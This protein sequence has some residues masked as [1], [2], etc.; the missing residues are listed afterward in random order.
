MDESVQVQHDDAILAAA[1]GLL[2]KMMNGRP[3]DPHNCFFSGADLV[4][5]LVTQ[6]VLEKWPRED[7][8]RMISNLLDEIEN[9]RHE[10]D[11]PGKHEKV[12]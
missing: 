8:V 5:Q 6:A 3:M 12:H 7:F 9:F 1:W 11:D 2:R 4:L 10:A